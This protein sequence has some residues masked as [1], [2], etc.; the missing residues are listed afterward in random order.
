MSREGEIQAGADT[1]GRLAFAARYRPWLIGLCLLGIC[2]VLAIAVAKMHPP[3]FFG[4]SEDDSI[5]FSSAKA[6]AAGHGYVLESVP[7]TPPATKY[8]V[9][10]PWI[11]SW[12]WRWAPTFPANLSVGIGLNVVCGFVYIVAAFFL[13]RGLAGLGDWERVLLVAYCGLHP[14]LIFHAGS[15]LSDLPF[16]AAVMSAMAVS[17]HAFRREESD[18]LV[19]CAGFLAGAAMLLRT[20]GLPILVGLALAIAIQRRWRN[21]AFFIAGAV[22]AWVVWL[23]VRKARSPLLEA[24]ASLC[25]GVW[26]MNWLYYTNYVGFWKADLLQ[27]HLLWQSVKQS[28]I[29]LFLQPG[30]Y[31]V[32]LDD[33]PKLLAYVP[34]LILSVASLYGCWR[35]MR[36]EQLSGV[37]LALVFYA[38]PVLIW[39]YPAMSRF[40]IPFLPLFVAGAWLEGKS[41]CGHILASIRANGLKKDGVAIVFLCFGISALALAIGW[42]FWSGIHVLVEQGNRRAAIGL[43]KREAYD[44]IKGHTPLEAVIIAYEDGALNLYSGR[45]AFRPVIFLPAGRFRPEI[46]QSELDCIAESSKQL[47]AEYWLVAQDDFSFEWQTAATRGLAREKELLAGYPVVFHSAGEGVRIYQIAPSVVSN[48]A[49]NAASKAESGAEPG[50]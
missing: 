48:V 32:E 25:S 47:G 38:I 2:A 23:L 20:L 42:S 29:L 13:L 6:L 36:G 21:L 18:W 24:G 7:G 30:S 11:L 16:A 37:W 15:L 22:P 31:L 1:G 17:V 45:K 14:I 28:F 9:L 5:Y 27:N 44:W 46:L 34:A 43:Q 49:S 26:R 8:P 41:I 19:L 4:L 39:D 35:W 10:Y 12:I 50:L 3:D 33:F 40:L